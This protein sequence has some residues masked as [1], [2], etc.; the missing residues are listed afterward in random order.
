MRRRPKAHYRTIRTKKGKKRILVN[1]GIKGRKGKV[2]RRMTV[3]SKPGVGRIERYPVKAKGGVLLSM[4]K[5][6]KRIGKGIKLGHSFYTPLK[7][8]ILSETGEYPKDSDLSRAQLVAFQDNY[9]DQL[10]FQRGVNV[11]P[12]ERY[13]KSNKPKR[14]KKFMTKVVNK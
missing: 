6:G 3:Y 7:E 10:G 11:G 13:H 12:L 9:Y 2:K 14:T 8:Q 4:S 1:K 5:R